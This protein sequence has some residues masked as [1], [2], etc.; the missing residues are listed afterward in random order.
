MPRSFT[1]V[2]SKKVSRLQKAIAITVIVSFCVSGCATIVHGTR[3]RISISSS[4][5]GATATV[6]GIELK[7]PQTISL[8]R[9]ND[10]VVTFEKPGYQKRQVVIRKQF[11]GLE[12][13]VGNILWLLP[14]L[15]VDFVAGGA[16]TLKP[17]AV[18]VDLQPITGGT[19]P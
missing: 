12:T 19:S 18:N 5:S 17:K 11:N 2:T 10:Y 16:W 8:E 6:D 13:I 4:P 3:Q 1:L 14:G 15:L 7:T 9:K